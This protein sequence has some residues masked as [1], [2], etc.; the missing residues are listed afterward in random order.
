[1]KLLA[2]LFC[3]VLPLSACV[4]DQSALSVEKSS[5]VVMQAPPDLVWAKAKQTVM[6]IAWNSEFA[7]L[8]R[9][10]VGRVRNVSLEGICAFVIDHVSNA[11]RSFSRT[12]GLPE[13]W[14]LRGTNCC[15]RCIADII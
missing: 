9:V 5:G 6:K 10:C 12:S 4:Q 7:R 3:L 15:D 2:A 1:M 8:R 14:H 11:K 13:G